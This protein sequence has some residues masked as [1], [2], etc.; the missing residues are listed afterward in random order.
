MWLRFGEG[1]RGRS[2][3]GRRGHFS[4]EGRRWFERVRE[5]CGRRR[6]AFW[7]VERWVGVEVEYEGLI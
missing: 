3:G 6:V 2:D 7:F 5:V 1:G 4:G